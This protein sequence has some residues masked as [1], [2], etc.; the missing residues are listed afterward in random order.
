[1]TPE[2][3]RRIEVIYPDE[4]DLPLASRIGGLSPAAIV[5]PAHHALPSIVIAV[6]RGAEREALEL[7]TLLDGEL[8]CELAAA[9]VC[10]WIGAL[11]RP[12]FFEL[13]HYAD[14]AQR[15]LERSADGPLLVAS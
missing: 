13:P 15:L 4:Q 1:M 8:R 9:G 7:L 3:S 10:L 14:K 5:R 2:L 12:A 6:H 11:P